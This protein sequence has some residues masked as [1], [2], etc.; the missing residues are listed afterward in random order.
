M[1]NSKT[2]EYYHASYGSSLGYLSE[3]LANK[4][5]Q[6][7]KLNYIIVLFLLAVFITTLAMSRPIFAQSDINQ[8]AIAGAY[9]NKV[10]I[11]K[12]FEENIQNKYANSHITFPT[13]G[14]AHIKKIKYINGKPIK[15]NIIEL[16]TNINK[17]LS[18]KPQTAS[19]NLNSKKTLRRIA[20]KDLGTII[21]INGGYFKPHRCASR[22]FDD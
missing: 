6:D 17:N 12:N 20:Q 16:N 19:T 22:S 7:R 9:P 1:I 11:Q 8:S 15:I 18:I 5:Y 2:T 13:K 10:Y 14:V 3:Y 21:A 4:S